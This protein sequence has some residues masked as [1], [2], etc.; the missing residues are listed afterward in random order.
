MMTLSEFEYLW[1]T[2]GKRYALLR[3]DL[4]DPDD[5]LPFD[6][7]KDNVILIE[8]DE[9]Y[10]R[11]VEQMRSAGIQIIEMTEWLDWKKLPDAGGYC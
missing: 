1:T 2:P 4:E 3:S 6:T 8:D 9:S 10:T 5:L 7:E 11:V